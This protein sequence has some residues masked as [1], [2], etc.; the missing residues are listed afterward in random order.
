[1]AINDFVEM[2]QIYTFDNSSLSNTSTGSI[3]SNGYYEFGSSDTNYFDK[4][5]ISHI[6]DSAFI[7]INI[8]TS[9]V[10]FANGFEVAGAGIC[11]KFSSQ[12]RIR[13]GDPSSTSGAGY[14]DTYAFSRSYTRGY[15]S[16]FRGNI[17]TSD[18]GKCIFGDVSYSFKI[19][20]DNPNFRSAIPIVNFQNHETNYITSTFLSSTND[21]NTLQKFQCFYYKS[22]IYIYLQFYTATYGGVSGG[23]KKKR[24]LY[25]L[26][27]ST[28]LSFLSNYYK[29]RVHFDPKFI[30]LVI[31]KPDND[32]LDVKIDNMATIISSN[33]GSVFN[34]DASGQIIDDFYSRALQ[35]YEFSQYT[36]E[37]QNLLNSGNITSSTGTTINTVQD[38]EF[39]GYALDKIPDNI[40]LKSNNTLGET[41]YTDQKSSTIY[42]ESEL[43][44]EYTQIQNELLYS[45]SVDNVTSQCVGLQ[46][47]YSTIITTETDLPG[48]INIKIPPK[49]KDL[50][51]KVIVKIDIPYD[52]SILVEVP[53]PDIDLPCTL[54]VRF[55]SNKDIPID[56]TVPQPEIDLPGKVAIRKWMPLDLFR[57]NVRVPVNVKPEPYTPVN[58]DFIVEIPFPYPQFTDMQFFLTQ[59]KYL[60]SV[61]RKMMLRSSIATVDNLFIPQ[62]YYSRYDERHLVFSNELGLQEGDEIR[63]TF[64]HNDGKFHIQKLEFYFKAQ[65]NASYYFLNMLSPYKKTIENTDVKFRVFVNRK[66]IVLNKDYT[67]N[68]ETGVLEFIN[69]NLATSTNDRIDLLCFFTGIDDTAVADLPMSGYIYLKRNMI[70]RNYNNNLMA[71][72]INGKLVPRNKI[73]HISNNIYKIKEDIKSRHDLQILNMSNRINSMVPF[74]KQST[75]F[76]FTSTLLQNGGIVDNF[77]PRYI[78]KNL[79]I[80][81]TV[82]ALTTYGRQHFYMYHNPIFFDPDYLLEKKDYYISFIHSAS[83]N[84]SYELN[85]YN[86][87]T[88]PNKSSVNVTLELHIKT[89]FEDTLEE[90]RSTILLTKLPATVSNTENEYSYA[91]LQIKQLIKLDI[92]NNRFLEMCDGVTIRIEPERTYQDQPSEVYFNMTASN[93]E[94][95]EKEQITVFEV[96]IS[97]KYDGLGQVLYSKL[98]TFNPEESNKAAIRA[99]DAVKT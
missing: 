32:I 44:D 53:K 62:R 86:N 73:L 33:S 54:T 18:Y 60:P 49:E 69:D 83:H 34:I 75:S 82:P 16:L 6:D 27:P 57:I 98:I 4:M 92:W 72:F 74:Y 5:S 63:F 10:S 24:A 48:K 68:N 81:I 30:Q 19:S 96:R 25:K 17:S 89:P 59:V 20:Y 70:D 91:S 1:M 38:S 76:P 41:I 50:P 23:F 78:E 52:F 42:S 64:C 29:V 39:S 77:H 61:P 43:N 22:N 65:G 11:R 55:K 9:T 99:A 45:I 2:G 26:T 31:Y 80:S 14:K 21:I 13:H 67:I 93:F 15:L 58:G 36:N 84:L 94:D 95:Y 90:S 87:D 35:E 46:Y 28:P 12:I 79:N 71:T 40:Y 8:T 85:F 37:S 88:D 97:D 51:G 56:I 7:P 3:I 66:E 47:N